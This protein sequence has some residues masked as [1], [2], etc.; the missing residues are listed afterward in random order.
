MKTLTKTLGMGKQAG[1]LILFIAVIAI[2]MSAFMPM[3][4]SVVYGEGDE[5]TSEQA[6]TAKWTVRFLDIDGTVLKVQEVEDGADAT[7]P[8]IKAKKGYK[9]LGWDSY[10]TG[11]TSDRTVSAVYEM[12]MTTEKETKGKLGAAGTAKPPEEKP[13]ETTTPE[14]TETDKVAI[15]TDGG[16]N[17]VDTSSDAITTPEIIKN[18]PT[19]TTVVEE[20]QDEGMSPTTMILIAAAALVV[21]AVAGYFIVSYVRKRRGYSA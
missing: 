2:L 17:V 5:I 4:S 8:D 7:P 3:T 6:I 19:P 12:V 15:A 1:K 10:F 21:L 13:A 11:V 14:T 16:M 20:G 9:F 18:N